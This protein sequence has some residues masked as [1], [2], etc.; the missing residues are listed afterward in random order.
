MK[1]TGDRNFALRA[2]AA[3]AFAALASVASVA[4]AQPQ[5]QGQVAVQQG[6]ALQD[7]NAP[8]VRGD[9]RIDIQL[10]N[11]CQ[12]KASAT[13]GCDVIRCKAEEPIAINSARGITTAKTVATA[14]AKKAL[15]DKLGENFSASET[16]KQ[17]TEQ[18]EREGLNSEAS[19]STLT[20]I[21]SQMSG[22]TQR[23]LVGVAIEEDG[24][25][26]SGATGKYVA[27]VIA[28]TSCRLQAA[29]AQNAAGMARA[30]A[31]QSPMAAQPAAAAASG[32][33]APAVSQN[34]ST[35][36]PYQ[37]RSGGLD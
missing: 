30:A 23:M 25:T 36:N 11:G 2:A 7:M 16:V 20:T 13:S 27:Y 28:K 35:L 33:I 21:T 5:V 9:D 22:N 6:P 37:R 18:L 15:S 32:P 12:V 26:P 34:P 24:V 29:A 14:K 17:V 3:A 10:P 31:G 8:R 4:V 19:A 1:K